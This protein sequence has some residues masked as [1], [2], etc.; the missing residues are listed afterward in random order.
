MK[1]FDFSS[2]VKYPLPK[3]DLSIEEEEEEAILTVLAL[4]AF[5]VMAGPIR[6]SPFLP[7]LKFGCGS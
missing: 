3:R 2:S 5:D 1:I 6:P 7:F 4:F